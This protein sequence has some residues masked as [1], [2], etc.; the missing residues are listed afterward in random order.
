MLSNKEQSFV[1]IAIEEALHS[2]C[3][4]M[5]GSVAVLQGKIV[6][7]GYN[8]HRSSSDGFM[9]N[10]C[11]CHAEISALREA[12]H[13]I[14][15]GNSNSIKI[16]KYLKS[17]YFKKITLYVVRIDINKNLKN[18]APCIDCIKII[19]KLGIKRIIYSDENNEFQKV[20]PCDYTI[21]YKSIGN[22]KIR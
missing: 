15:N 3:L 12:Y 10:Q 22:R 7:R 20:K 5:H 2:N 1:N 21:V 16:D 14:N 17:K 13:N 8:H 18:S 4:M 19:N 6:G 9:E 11:T